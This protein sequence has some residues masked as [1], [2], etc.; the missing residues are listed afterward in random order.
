MAIDNK[1]LDALMHAYLDGQLSPN[2][3]KKVVKYLKEHPNRNEELKKNKK[4]TNYIIAAFNPILE[5]PIS[6]RLQSILFGE[7]TNL[8]T[9][10]NTGAN[11]DANID[12]NVEA[13]NFDFKT[14][15]SQD[16]KHIEN[17]SVN[18]TGDKQWN[19]VISHSLH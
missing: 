6:D 8:A 3:T 17:E 7:K 4:I 13:I 9:A 5:L 14:S 11:V 18:R 1:T 12:V 19:E 15:T 16:E 2:A 10:T